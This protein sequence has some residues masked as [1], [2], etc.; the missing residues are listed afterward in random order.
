MA[1]EIAGRFAAAIRPVY[2]D[3]L[4]GV[5][6]FGARARGGAPADADV[7]TI[8][9]L[10]SVEHY[11]AELERTSQICASLSHE[12]DLVVSRIFVAA[13]VWDGGEAGVP[14]T[15]RSEAVAV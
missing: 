8:V 11:G 1:L 14:P 7:E 5:Y 13:A 3:S 2:G 10:D 12:A 15:V 6:L 9:V 4:K